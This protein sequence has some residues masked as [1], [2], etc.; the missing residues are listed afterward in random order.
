MLGWNNKCTSL[1]YQFRVVISADASQQE[2]SWLQ[3]VCR[4]PS[5]NLSPVV[6]IHVCY[7]KWKH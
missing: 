5:G 3:Q 6:Q 2:S 4:F 7:V 1:G